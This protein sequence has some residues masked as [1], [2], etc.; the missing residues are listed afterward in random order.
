M[1]KP[2]ITLLALG[3][4]LASCDRTGGEAKELA[5]KM[6]LRDSLNLQIAELGTALAEVEEWIAENDTNAIKNLTQ[7]TTQPFALST[8]KHF[9]EVHGT[10]KSDKNAMLYPGMGGEIKKIQVR[11]GDKVRAGQLLVSIDAA[12]LGN[13]IRQM[14]AQLDLATAIHE[15]QERLWKDEMIGSE[16]QYLEAKANK[17]SLEASLASLRAQL[18]ASQIYAPYS[19]VVDEIFPNVG[20]MANPTMPVLRIVAPSIVSIESDVAE[21]YLSALE[22][23]DLVDIVIGI[24]DTLKGKVDQV[25][26]FIN[27]GNRT[28]KIT[29][30]LVEDGSRLLPNQLTTVRICNMAEDSAYV[31]SPK[32]IMEDANGDSYVYV[33]DSDHEVTSVRKV[34]VKRLMNGKKEVLVERTNELKPGDRL[35]DQGARLVVENQRVRVKKNDKDA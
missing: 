11:Q 18:R 20:D 30:R 4:L 25:G 17:E 22:K 13:N 33:T 19:G 6:E 34:Y 29:T 2:I 31:L 26:G 24:G 9:V 23:E 8:Y 15:R 21:E 1:N 27:P 5:M 32:L 28:F 14:E 3:V 16:V 12:A 7:I 10:V 35:V